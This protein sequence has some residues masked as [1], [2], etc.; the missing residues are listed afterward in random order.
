M[1]VCVPAGEATQ[2]GEPR[3][4]LFGAP[5]SNSNS[6]DASADVEGMGG[7]R[8]A[9]SRRGSDSDSSG[10]SGKDVSPLEYFFRHPVV[11][12]VLGMSAL[13]VCYRLLFVGSV[14]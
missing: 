1:P 11:L 7:S 6:G 2:V 4:G 13:S 5:S 10:I 8:A 14:P 3:P 12:L 9:G